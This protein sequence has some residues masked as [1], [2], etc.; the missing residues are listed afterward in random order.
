RRFVSN[1]TTTLASGSIQR[2]VP[3]KP[4]CPKGRPPLRSP[5][6]ESPFLLPSPPPRRAHSRRTPIPFAVEPRPKR[7][8]EPLAHDPIEA[9]RGA[10]RGARSIQLV[11]HRG[12]EGEHGGS[13]AEDSRVPGPSEACE[14]PRVLVVHGAN[15]TAAAP[16]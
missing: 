10:K 13:T 16:L 15:D 2:L 14:G 11:E 8:P 3:V 7:P 5:A 9:D 12:A 6:P 4:K 1:V